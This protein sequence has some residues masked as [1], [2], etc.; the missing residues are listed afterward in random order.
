[1]NQTAISIVRNTASTIVIRGLF[2][3]T[4]ILLLLLIAKR[5]GPEDFGRL[6]LVLS[7]VEI[8]R[9][10]ADFGVDIVTIRR[11]S[12][13]RLLSERLLGNALSLKLISATAGYVA[14]IVVF[15]L[16]YHNPEGLELLLIVGTSLYTSLLM[17]AFVSYFQAN[18]TMSSIIISSLASAIS[19][20][21][22]TVIGL[23]NGWSLI[24]L[25]AIIP[26]SELINLLMT[27]TIY[28]R[29]SSV[30]LRLDKRIILSLLKEGLPVAIGGIAVVV[31]SRLDNLML[32]WFL[33]ERGVGQYA[34]SFRITEPFSL[35]FS[36]LSLS[37]FASMSRI[38]KSSDSTDAR[39]TIFNV[40]AA[41][42]SLSLVAAIFISIFSK[43]ILGL[44]SHEYAASVIVLQI[45]SFSMVFKA[46]NAQLTAFIN[47][48]GMFSLI[49]LIAFINLAINVAMNLLM[50]PIYGIMGAAIAVIVTEA[51]N[52]VIQS[53]T[54]I[55]LFKFSFRGFR[56][57]WA[58][59]T[60]RP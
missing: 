30:V 7:L 60:N 51:L 26:V 32:G 1:M 15:W 53:G 28:G 9:V 38:G 5:F 56:N 46:V 23:Y 57:K 10:F 11:F 48:R 13:N 21:S 40:V 2:G 59:V 35:I 47:S 44:I 39:K 45:L 24:Y 20:I 18:L 27:A 6:S 3:I 55:Y 36:S 17:N 37:L 25:S 14:S 50:I 54:V 49:T 42:S 58:I 4:R 8:V 34:A 52:T 22:L 12:L 41:V 43:S 19:Y 31:Y 16:V 29:I 33:G